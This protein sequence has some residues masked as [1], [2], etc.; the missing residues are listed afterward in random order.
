MTEPEETLPPNEA[1]TV[2]Y[3]HQ[4]EVTYSWH[5]SM[6][7]LVGYDMST[8]G[9]I[10]AGGYIS[11]RC[12]S[13]GLVEARNRAVRHF[14]EDR[15]ADWLWW[16]DT[17]MGFAP[18]T[19]ERLLEAADPAERPVVGG[20]CFS[21]RETESD[22]M[23][24]W[25]TAP[26]PTVFDWA[27][28][29]TADG[30]QQ[31]FAVRWD[32][33][34]DTLTQVAGTGSACILIHRSV[35]ERLADKF[36][37][38]WYNRVP[39]T[40]TGQLLS[41]DLSFC[42]RAGAANIPVHVHTG[43]RTTH[44]KPVWLAEQDYVRYLLLN[45]KAVEPV[46]PAADRAVPRYAIV[47]THN[48]PVLLS[49]LV[50]SLGRQ[51]DTIVVVDN[52]SDPPVDVARLREVAPA[53]TVEVIR[54]E[55]QPPNLARLWNVMF[56]RCA[57]LAKESGHDEYDVAVFNDDAV[58]P[59][60]WYDVVS[61]GLRG[62]DTAAVAH[63]GTVPVSRLELRTRIDLPRPARMCPWAF[64]TRGELGLRADESMRWWYFDDDF[65]RTA[66]LGGGVLQVP[67]P[68]V[69]NSLANSTTGGAL[70]EQAARDQA[71]FAAKWAGR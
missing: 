56:D 34:S 66:R 3:V 19:I 23:G 18:D 25:H 61:A 6:V 32:Y 12:G 38:I 27:K 11:M 35:F 67:G 70:A 53:V 68:L 63:T 30:E 58:V 26:T 10:M 17:D 64:V 29:D 37:P 49:V 51:A 42:L 16:V 39:N 21:M 65:D 28:I 20:L 4:N 44:Q 24:G 50:A 36:G 69:V 22:E 2:A 40:T 48:R 33:P 14:L 7:E 9:R 1:V 59:A 15:P 31:G 41:E 8:S 45:P 55:E 5:H 57:E 46:R 71:T 43:V 60:G 54:D 62:H 52:A 47:P 13:D